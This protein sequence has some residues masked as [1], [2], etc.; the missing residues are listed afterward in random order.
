MPSDAEDHDDHVNDDQKMAAKDDGEE[1][2]QK[3]DGD[4]GNEVEEGH[5]EDEEI[6]PNSPEPVA[7]MPD[8][9]T[10][11]S[12]PNR[13]FDDKSE[14]KALYLQFQL[15]KGRSIRVTDNTSKRYRL[16]CN[17]KE[18]GIVA[19]FQRKD[20]K[21]K[22]ISFDN[23]HECDPA[24]AE[25]F[26]RKRQIKASDIKLLYQPLAK[27][28]A[29]AGDPKQVQDSVKDL[30]IDL[31]LTQARN[32]LLRSKGDHTVSQIGQYFLLK[33]YFDIL[34]KSDPEGTFQLEFFRPRWTKTKQFNRYYISFSMCHTAWDHCNKV[35]VSKGTLSNN[36]AF[37]HTILLAVSY[38]GN[39]EMVLLAY[40]CVTEE[41]TSNWTWFL[42][43]LQQD[44]AGIEVFVGNHQKGVD[45]RDFQSLILRIGARYSRCVE[46]LLSDWKQE[47]QG[48]RWDDAPIQSAIMALVKARTEA[49][50]QYRLEQL[51]SLNGVVARWLDE[52]KEQFAEY[53]FVQDEKCR[54]GKLVNH[55]DEY[56]KGVFNVEERAVPI[57]D[58]TKAIADCIFKTWH[59]RRERGL[60]WKREGEIITKYAFANHIEALETATQLHVQVT[61][62]SE[63]KILANV[64]AVAESNLTYAVDV[65]LSAYRITC[66]CHYNQIMK[67]PCHHGLAIIISENLGLEDKLDSWYDKLFHVDN[68]ISTYADPPPSITTAGNLRIIEMI[69][70]EFRNDS[71]R[72]VKGKAYISKVPQ[73]RRNTCKD[74][75]SR[76]HQSGTC[77]QRSIEYR[78]NTSKDAARKYA[79]SLIGEG[80]F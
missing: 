2:R 55:A 23:A 3:D 24:A 44:F 49:Q 34:S 43:L 67:L 41:N 18:G 30:G 25:Q 74:C 9:A 53:L 54:F 38:D 72:G 60:Q 10:L 57:Y 26:S 56:F 20:G 36:G 58:L 76:G 13:R 62:R 52:R 28:I 40:A 63:E 39:D 29:G 75:G 46:T 66:P 51:K 12:D 16:R 68:Y 61:F 71:R 8:P 21:W 6:A 27:K 4:E 42:G 47:S 7:K 14:I 69:P 19:T 37:E 79:E 78:Y 70:P 59:E 32:M 64:Q 15:S 73:E 45:S 48:G 22:V 5:Q 31:K 33:S 50:Y 17:C 65:N 35:L 80:L 1:E 11:L 77:T